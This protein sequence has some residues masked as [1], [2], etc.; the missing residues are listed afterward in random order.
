MMHVCVIC[1]RRGRT[2]DKESTSEAGP[3]LVPPMEGSTHSVHASDDIPPPHPVSTP[4]SGKVDPLEDATGSS[5]HAGGSEQIADTLGSPVAYDQHLID[6]SASSFSVA[7]RGPEPTLPAAMS[8]MNSIPNGG[9]VAQEESGREAHPVDKCPH[10]S[11]ALVE[12]KQ[13]EVTA[14]PCAITEDMMELERQI[15][16][17]LDGCRQGVNVIVQNP[18]NQDVSCNNIP[19]NPEESK[20]IDNTNRQD[21][22][23]PPSSSGQDGEESCFSLAAALKE[24]HKLLVISGQGSARAGEDGAVSSGDNH[25]VDVQDISQESD[26]NGQLDNDLH[27]EDGIS[28]QVTDET[29]PFIEEDVPGGF[30]QV[31]SGYD[32]SSDCMESSAVME[33]APHQPLPDAVLN[34]DVDTGAMA[35]S[36]D[37]AAEDQQHLGLSCDS[38][39]VIHEQSSSVQPSDAPSPLSAVERIVGAG[40]TMQ[41]ALVALDRADGNVELALLALL[42]RNIVV[43]T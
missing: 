1:R 24:L 13:Q 26:Q 36:I 31:S 7:A 5:F 41:D 32:S 4:T 8:A 3:S 19:S 12:D 16:P 2:A 39:E 33:S 23:K 17:D 14:A 29:S 42:A 6:S 34:H 40:F 37:S 11:S 20:D 18:K 22:P 15:I 35:D 9:L 43:P 27:Q 21:Y 10:S 30:L 28:C 25:A 38:G